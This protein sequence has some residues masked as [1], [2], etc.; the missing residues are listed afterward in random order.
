MTLTLLRKSLLKIIMSN[1]SHHLRG[2][3]SPNWRLHRSQQKDRRSRT[4]N[5][6]HL[7]RVDTKIRIQQQRWWHPLR[8]KYNQESPWYNFV[9]SPP[10]GN[11]R[12]G[13]KMVLSFHPCKMFFVQFRCFFIEL[14]QNSNYVNFSKYLSYRC[15]QT[16]VHIRSLFFRTPGQT[17]GRKV[18]YLKSAAWQVRGKS[19]WFS[20]LSQNHRF[21]DS[22]TAKNWTATHLSFSCSISNPYLKLSQSSGYVENLQG[23]SK[24]R[25]ILCR[26]NLKA[27]HD[28]VY[29]S[30]FYKITLFCDI[31]SLTAIVGMHILQ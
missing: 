3:Q 9:F 27:V 25:G 22:L 13:P 23:H 14:S 26:S 15:L 19:G 21:L 4:C 31:F 1:L 8:V 24:S 18:I 30:V 29:F 11:H 10:T 16:E 28:T 12:K 6:L 5:H 2:Y 20:I 7:M 17:I